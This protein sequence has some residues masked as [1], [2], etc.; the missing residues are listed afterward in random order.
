MAL[1][2][3]SECLRFIT[4][5]FFAPPSQ[6]CTLVFAFLSGINHPDQSESRRPLAR[7]KNVVHV[8]ALIP[9]DACLSS[10][11]VTLKNPHLFWFMS[12]SHV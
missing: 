4:E 11:L 1:P 3:D 2:A 5:K 6:L 9:D 8:V 12:N 7:N 10:T